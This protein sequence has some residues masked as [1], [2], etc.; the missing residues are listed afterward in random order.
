MLALYGTA[1]WKVYTTQDEK[2]FYPEAEWVQTPADSGLPYQQ[3]T[4]M[5][6]DGVRLS[7]WHVLFPRALQTALICHGNAGNISHRLEE[8]RVY[9]D[10]GLNVF[11]FDYRGYGKSEGVPSEEGFYRDAEAAF[12]YVTG[13]LGVSPDRVVVCGRSL[14]A[15]V[16]SHLASHRKVG[17]LILE[18]GFTSI[19]D[20]A[21]ALYPYFP[22]R[23]LARYRFNTLENVKKVICP[24][25]VIHSRADKLVPFS[26]G[27]RIFEA[28]RGPKRFVE[29]SGPHNEGYAQS[30]EVYREGLRAFLEFTGF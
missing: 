2:I 16:A 17:G 6:A 30:V 8:I 11:I 4:L 23:S 1:L 7:A 22:V 28:V 12:D 14:G 20:M 29:I 26:H 24:V 3:H 5:S 27:K 13:T 10:L 21:A 15:A 19:G 18:S 9:R 25:L